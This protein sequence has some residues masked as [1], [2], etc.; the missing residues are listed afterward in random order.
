MKIARNHLTL[1]VALMVT[2]FAGLVACAPAA[3]PPPPTVA[4]T[5][6]PAPTTAPTTAPAQ[7]A[8]FTIELAQKDQLGKFLADGQGRTLYLFT[9]DI[10]GTSNCTDKCA[11]S[12]PPILSGAAP[13]LKEGLNA[14]LIGTTQ[15][16]EG[17]TQLTYNGW[18]LYYYG[19]DQQAGDTTG[20]AVGNVWWVISA[21]GNPVKPTGIE[22]SSNTSL[23]KFLADDAGRTVYAFT[24]DSKGTTVCYDK[25]EQSWPPV[26][27]LGQATL[28]DGVDSAMIGS[29]QRKDG[30]MQVTYNGIPLYYYIKDQTPGSTAGQAVGE[31]WFVVTPDGS[32]TK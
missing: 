4:P 24:K 23:G 5:N 27:S 8:A 16:K 28:K 20:Q 10:P 30:T 31:V 1:G 32:L 12:W 14:S 17:T 2:A 21:E 19:K 22:V 13:D 7:A 26:V 3:T 15:R 29:V 9:K 25:C 18:P 6:V 11:Q